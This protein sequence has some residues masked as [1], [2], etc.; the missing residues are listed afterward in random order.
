MAPERLS[1]QL[2]FVL[3]I[4]PLKQVLRQTLL[5]S[6]S[7]RENSAEHSWHIALMAPLLFEYAP[8]GPTC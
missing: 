4:D 6:G 3:E 8:P 1:Q 2:Q 7:R 5:T